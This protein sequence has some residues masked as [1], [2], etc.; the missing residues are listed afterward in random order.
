MDLSGLNV[1]SLLPELVLAGGGLMVM[2]VDGFRKGQDCPGLR[3]LS[4]ATVLVATFFCLNPPFVGSGYF[5][6]VQADGLALAARF[7]ILLVLALLLIGSEN[8]LVQRKLPRA[9]T[10][11]LTLFAA[12]GMLALASAGDL[13]ILFLGIEI[14][15][16]SLY[17]LAGMLAIRSGSREAALKYFL[18]G[19]YASG[20]LLFGMALLYG[21]TGTTQL[22]AMAPLVQ[23]NWIAT[24]GA[25][26][27]LVGFLFKV[28][29][30]PFHAW[31]PDVYT[32]SPTFVTAFMSTAAKAAAFA[33]FGRA[34]LPLTGLS[35]HWV[36]LIGVSAA[37]TMI[38]GN[39]SALVQTDVKRM[40]AYSSVAHAGYMLLGMMALGSD[41]QA[42]QAVIF[43]LM[44]YGLVNVALF[45]LAAQ[46]SH[47]GSGTYHLDDYKGLA[48]RSPLVALLLTI[49]V[50]SLA[51]IPPTAGFIGK[52]Y[53]FSAAVKAD[54]IGLAILGVL[55]SVVSV[56][57]YLRFLVLAWFHEPVQEGSP[58]FGTGLLVTAVLAAFGLLLLGIWPSL[59]LGLTQGI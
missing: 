43:Y 39:F 53:L 7:V 12:T 10:L 41:P 27:M 58:D 42:I 2:L 52:F 29:A 21:A 30:V 33:A 16:I 20:F 50:F 38:L 57:Y 48:K 6:A 14:M 47:A 24:G 51:G 35:G 3:W 59:W 18:T 45:M 46:I 4:L 40:L 1:L 49:F 34:F 44:P 5:G 25:V 22:A 13:I 15:S 19:S 23:D 56:F 11:A 9:E 55:T 31:A 36:P 37:L 8:Y 26:L 32:G 54:F 17:C 28:G